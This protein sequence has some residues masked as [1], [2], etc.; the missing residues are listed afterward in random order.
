MYDIEKYCFSAYNPLLYNEPLITVAY[1]FVLDHFRPCVF[2]RLNSEI[3]F[4]QG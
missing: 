1:V 4:P 3:Y 2:S